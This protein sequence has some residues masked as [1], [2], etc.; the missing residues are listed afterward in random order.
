MPEER[1]RLRPMR[2]IRTKAQRID[3]MNFTRPKMAVAKSFSFCP[4]V[5]LFA[6]HQYASNHYS[7]RCI[8]GS[9]NRGKGTQM[10]LH[11]LKILRRIDRNA[12]RPT[13]L[14]EQLTH[15]TQLNPIQIRFTREQ[16]SDRPEPSRSHRRLPLAIELV[17][18]IYDF[19]LDVGMVTWQLTESGQRF[20]SFFVTPDFDEPTW[21]L[22]TKKRECE[23]YTSEHEMH[24]RFY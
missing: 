11:H 22:A 15:N 1:A 20:E 3:E 5:P 4:V 9:C 8:F 14:T 7:P 24:A 21:G 12:I 13:P 19:A 18:D 23:D 6:D 10:D 16:L 2:S 17:V